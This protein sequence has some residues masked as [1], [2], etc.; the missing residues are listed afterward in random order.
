M[1]TL[2]LAFTCSKRGLHGRG[3]MAAMAQAKDNAEKHFTIPQQIA[4]VTKNQLQGVVCS[5]V[6]LIGSSPCVYQIL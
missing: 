6:H 4:I 5:K 1:V 2:Y 3:S